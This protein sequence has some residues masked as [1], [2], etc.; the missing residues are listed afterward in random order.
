MAFTPP[1]RLEDPAE[2]VPR[3]SAQ[4][5]TLDGSQKP[6]L[7]CACNERG[8]ISV[9]VYQAIF[10]V[11]YFIAPDGTVL[12]SEQFHASDQDREVRRSLLAERAS[13]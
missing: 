13:A 2:V 12:S 9:Y 4:Q 6:L 7:V 1:R 11:R 3:T 10:V 5:Q 8:V